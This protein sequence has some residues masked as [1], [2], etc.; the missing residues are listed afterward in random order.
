MHRAEIPAHRGKR[1]LAPD[2]IAGNGDQE[3]KE[4]EPA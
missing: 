1:T 4:E 2:N 3:D